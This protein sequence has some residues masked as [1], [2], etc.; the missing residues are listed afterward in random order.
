MIKNLAAGANTSLFS[1]P[2][3]PISLGF[4]LETS[5]VCYANSIFARLLADDFS[6]RLC[7][8]ESGHRLF[9][10]ILQKAEQYQH[11][12]LET[13]E[14]MKYFLT[15]QDYLAYFRD[16]PASIKLT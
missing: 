4:Q 3:N 11:L 7:I 1:G 2:Q 16:I 9:V 5:M 12:F 8:E 13:L 10:N 6:K 14:S 15:S